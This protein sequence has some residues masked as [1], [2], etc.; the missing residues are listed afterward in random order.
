MLARW[1][2]ADPFL[3][4]F[5]PQAPF[6]RFQNLGD[7]P[8]LPF[9]TFMDRSLPLVVLPRA[10]CAFRLGATPHAGILGCIVALPRTPH[11]VTADCP[12]SRYPDRPCPLPPLLVGLPGCPPRSQTLV[13]SAWLIA[14][15]VLR[16]G[17]RCQVTRSS[18]VAPPPRPGVVTDRRCVTPPPPLPEQLPGGVVVTGRHLCPV[19]DVMPPVRT[20]GHYVGYLW[21]SSLVVGC[22]HKPLRIA[23]MI[24]G[25]VAPHPPPAVLFRSSSFPTRVF[26][27]SVRTVIV[28][29]RVF[30]PNG[31]TRTHVHGPFALRTRSYCHFNTHGVYSYLVDTLWIFPR[32]PPPRMFVGAQI[33]PLPSWLGLVPCRCL[34]PTGWFSTRTLLTFWPGG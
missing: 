17:E 32:Y 14:C 7:S 3:N 10:C 27:M 21:V 20:Y 19:V 22:P 8:G 34:P 11:L 28:G 13:C 18:L 25:W 31:H 5:N 15:P 23:G 33:V 12:P 24:Y 4:V 1:Y 16:V 9:P 30:A 29:E 2:R 6:P 26:G